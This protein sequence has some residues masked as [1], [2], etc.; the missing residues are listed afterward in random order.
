MDGW[1]SKLSLSLSLSLCVSGWMT[2]CTRDKCVSNIGCVHEP[3]SGAACDLD[4]NPC[5]LD[6]CSAAGVCTFTGP[7]PCDDGNPCT[8]DSCAAVCLAFS[9]TLSRSLSLSL[10]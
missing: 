9:I 4:N 7:N 10:S 8:V 5:T 3:T 6:V 2:A 1:K